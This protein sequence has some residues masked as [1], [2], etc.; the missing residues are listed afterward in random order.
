MTPFKALR[1]RERQCGL[2]I[3]DPM[4]DNSQRFDGRNNTH[5]PNLI[6]RWVIL[7]NC[8]KIRSTDFRIIERLARVIPFD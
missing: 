5:N 7:F 4:R 8:L 6:I 1:P 2:L 3:S